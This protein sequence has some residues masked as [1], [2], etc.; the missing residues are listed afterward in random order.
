[1]GLFN[2]QPRVRVAFSSKAIK[3][4]RESTDALNGMQPIPKSVLRR[5]TR[6][7]W[8]AKQEQILAYQ[9]NRPGSSVGRE[10]EN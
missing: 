6:E 2:R 1:M 7:E 10:R 3:K 5:Q 9:P 4:L 8:L